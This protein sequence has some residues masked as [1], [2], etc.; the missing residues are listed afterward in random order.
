MLFRSEYAM[1]EVLTRR[2]LVTGGL[3]AVGVSVLGGA[4]YLAGRNGLIPP[5][6]NRG[7]LGAGETLTY[8]SQRLL[9]SGQQLAREFTRAEISKVPIVN[10]PAPV[11]AMYRGMLTDGF[12]DWR[13]QIEGLVARPMSLSLEELRNLPAESRILLHACEEIGRAHV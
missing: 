7:L 9:T 5:D 12:K 10:G 1:S 6:Y 13:L 3:S 4:T 11:D 8:A 2:T